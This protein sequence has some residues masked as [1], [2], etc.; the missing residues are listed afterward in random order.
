MLRRI[1]RITLILTLR[2]SLEYFFKIFVVFIEVLPPFTFFYFCRSVCRLMYFSNSEEYIRIIRRHINFLN[3]FLY[4]PESKYIRNSPNFIRI[5]LIH[6]S[7]N[8]WNTLEVNWW[9]DE[10]S[11]EFRGILRRRLDYQKFADL[12][13]NLQNLLFVNYTWRNSNNSKNIIRISQANIN[14]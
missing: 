14:C 13:W 11:Q 9:F 10:I 3:Y 4:N 1:F 7:R 12:A 8:L 5:L 6:H 2:K